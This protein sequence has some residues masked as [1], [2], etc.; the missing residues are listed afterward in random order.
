MLATL[1]AALLAVSICAAEEW[2]DFQAEGC[3]PR[4]FVANHLARRREERICGLGFQVSR[5]GWPRLLKEPVPFYS[6]Q[7]GRV[8]GYRSQLRP[9]LDFGTVAA[10]EETGGASPT[11]IRIEEIDWAHVVVSGPPALK[12]YVSRLTPAVVVESN[13][14]RLTFFAGKGAAQPAFFAT[15]DGVLPRE[16]LKTARLGDLDKT[17]LLVWFGEAAGFTSTRLPYSLSARTWVSPPKAPVDCPLLF[18]FQ[19]APGALEIRE[20]KGLLAEFPKKAGRVAVLPLFGDSYPPVSE[21]E[22]WSAG[23][24]EAVERQCGWW[25]AHLSEVPLT[26]RETPRYDE[27]ADAVTVS[28][29]VRFIRL[30]DGGMRFAPLPPMLALAKESGFPLSVSGNVARTSVLTAVGPYVGIEGTDEYT[31]RVSGLGKYVREVRT[32]GAQRREPMAVARL[33]RDEVEKVIGAGHLAPWK[34]PHWIHEMVWWNPGE[35]LFVLGETLPLLDENLRAEVLACMR[36][37]RAGYPPEEAVAVMR[38]DGGARRERYRTDR[39]EKTAA[40]K[41]SRE[42]YVINRLIPEQNLYYL[43]EFARHADAGRETAEDWPELRE[44]LYPY[45]ERQDWATLGRYRWKQTK[46]RDPPYVGLG[47]V[48]DANHRFAALVGALRLA[49]SSGDRG[50][51]NLL[52]GCFARACLLRY[53]M[54]RYARYLHEN[55]LVV[56]PTDPNLTREDWVSYCGERAANLWGR[57][58]WMIRFTEGSW[59]GRLY[60]YDWKGP[61]D[62]VRSVVRLDQF[63]VQFDELLSYFFGKALLPYRGMVPELGRFLAD[64]QRPRARAFV[65]RV[66]ENMPEW[67]LFRCPTNIGAEFDYLAPGESYQCFLARAWILGEPPEAL[68]GFLDVPWMARGDLYYIHKLA[69]TIKAYRGVGWE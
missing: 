65:D 34:P 21:T 24:P 20:G 41:V 68:A 64:Y 1:T 45:L 13:S 27:K 57:P 18:I 69:E 38:S 15:P 31:W 36:K 51:E 23:L 11:P 33:L 4:P 17:W 48:I 7:V 62:D 67:Y 32:V 47:G 19:N 58:D 12:V 37:E 14:R 54:G 44:I 26:A 55:R 6:I 60:T 22:T 30:R 43:S 56:L 5:E 52:W 49:R 66:A 61:E 29:K 9:P 8:S 25:A 2:P 16:K 42:S 28:V 63:G 40:V 53:A 3:G 50:G 46:G 35:T 10:G 39:D 59:V